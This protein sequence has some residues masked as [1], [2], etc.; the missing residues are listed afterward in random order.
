[1]IIGIIGAFGAASIYPLMFYLYGKVAG[2]FVDYKIYEKLQSSS[3]SSPG[4]TSSYNLTAS[5]IILYFV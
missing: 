2:V 3:T 4:T 5:K 1:M